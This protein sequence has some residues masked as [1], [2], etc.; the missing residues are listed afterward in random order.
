MFRT[1]VWVCLLL[2]V[3]LQSGVLALWPVDACCAAEAEQPCEEDCPYPCANCFC[4]ADRSPAALVR[5]EPATRRY[6]PITL[7]EHL[8]PMPPTPH[9]TEILHVPKA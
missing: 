7:A 5:F 3:V 4:C 6:A 1:V 8:T 2:L 9:P